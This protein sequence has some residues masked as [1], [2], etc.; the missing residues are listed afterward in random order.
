MRLPK[1]AS[2]K[3]ILNK[4]HHMDSLLCNLADQYFTGYI[5]ITVEGEKTIED[6]YLLFNCGKVVGA[7]YIGKKDFF[8]K[9]A[10]KKIK[11]AWN[12][13]GILDLNKFTPFQ[14]QLTLEENP[15]TLLMTMKKILEIKAKPETEKSVAERKSKVKE[16]KE[17]TKKLSLEVE[18]ILVEKEHSVTED[19]LKKR[20]ERVALLKKFGLKEPEDDFVDAVLQGF[21]LPCER[22]L[23]KKSKELKKE[24]VKKLKK[25]KKLK[26]LDLYINPAKLHNI[27][28]FDIDVY[29]KPL[30]KK[31]EK[32]VKSVID[33]TFK[34]ML[35]FPYKKGFKINAA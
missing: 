27:V 31:I 24:I 26:K 19:I 29:V 16:V 7:Q 21:N 9:K 34:E 1:G 22:D 33:D 4:E 32:E 14:L 8:S 17:P 18:E 12:L 5:R 6:G 23:N 25:S 30:N 15:E 28:E 10:L 20:E 13:E 2:Y 3:L 35:S 11:E